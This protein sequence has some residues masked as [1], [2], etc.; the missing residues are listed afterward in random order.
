MTYPKGKVTV[1]NQLIPVKRLGNH[2]TVDYNV[3][4]FIHSL[5]TSDAYA[6]VN[7]ATIVSY[8]G[9]SPAWR[10]VII[11]PDA[12]ILLVGSLKKMHLKLLIHS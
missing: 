11:W 12:G 2:D 6:S 10:Q 9:L 4:L 5:R 8:S 1:R 7:Q 3:D